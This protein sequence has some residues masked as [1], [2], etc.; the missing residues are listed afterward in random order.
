MGIPHAA[1]TLYIVYIIS[2]KILYIKTK[3][4]RILQHL[5]RTCQCLSSAVHCGKHS[6]NETNNGLDTD[7]LP[8]RMVNPDEYEPL[9]PAVNHS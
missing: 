3:K 8:D 2:K 4:N 7:F 9:I 1:L 6:L 5:K